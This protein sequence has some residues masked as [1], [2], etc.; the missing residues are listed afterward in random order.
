MKKAAKAKVVGIKIQTRMYSWKL[1]ESIKNAMSYDVIQVKSF[2]TVMERLSLI[3]I[4]ASVVSTFSKNGAF[5]NDLMGV[6]MK[7]F[8]GG[9]PPDP[10]FY[11]LRSHLISVPQYE[12]YS[13]GPENPVY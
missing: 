9:K 13:D 2:K 10:R 5:S 8:P 11:F 12:F 7:N 6:V 3:V 1:P 4:L